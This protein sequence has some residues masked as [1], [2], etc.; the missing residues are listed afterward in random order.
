[1]ARTT[2]DYSKLKGKIKEK[3]GSQK[4]FAEKLGITE[5]TMTAKLNGNAY[6]HQGEIL[7]ATKILD[8]CLD[9]I[10]VYFFATEVQ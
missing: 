8:I 1:M 2:F 4:I 3:C 5:S 7:K 10:S 6:F 9:D